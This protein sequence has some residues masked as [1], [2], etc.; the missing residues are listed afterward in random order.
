[1]DMY[2]IGSLHFHTHP[3][4]I[5]LSYLYPDD[6]PLNPMCWWVNSIKNFMVNPCVNQP[7]FFS[8]YQGGSSRRRC[9]E[10]V[11]PR[12]HL[13][14]LERCLWNWLMFSRSQGIWGIDPIFGTHQSESFWDPNGS[15]ASSIYGKCSWYVMH[16]QAMLLTFLR[17]VCL[18]MWYASEKENSDRENHDR[19]QGPNESKPS[20]SSFFKYF[21]ADSWRPTLCTGWH[22]FPW[23]VRIPQETRQFNLL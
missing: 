5:L 6:I 12:D 4:I 16:Q 7:C 9:E 19:L 10:Q 1:M 2:Y 14:S 13:W 17:W 21:K 3:T 8:A 15:I 18:K 22:G 23:W 11:R 20:N